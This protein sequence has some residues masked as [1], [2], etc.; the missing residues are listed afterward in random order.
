[1]HLYLAMHVESYNLLL[2]PNGTQDNNLHALECGAC[3]DYC[4][5]IDTLAIII[6]RF[7]VVCLQA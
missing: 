4:Y 5:I 3:G 6:P 7:M 1:M 2:G